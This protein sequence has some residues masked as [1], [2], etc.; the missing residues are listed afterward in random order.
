MSTM[1]DS[2]LLRILPAARR[3]GWD[4]VE[5]GIAAVDREIPHVMVD[6]IPH[7]RPEDLDAYAAEHRQP[8]H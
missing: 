5:L 4:P 1:P 7:F 2:G 8:A 3:I 6:G